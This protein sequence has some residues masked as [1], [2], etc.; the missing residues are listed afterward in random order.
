LIK[1]KLQKYGNYLELH[2]RDNKKSHMAVGIP[3]L[4]GFSNVL[5]INRLDVS[6]NINFIFKNIPFIFG[7]MFFIFRN[8][9][10]IFWRIKP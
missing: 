4:F 5:K 10:F 2:Q 3:P 8:I 6:R 7:K 9:K 1:N